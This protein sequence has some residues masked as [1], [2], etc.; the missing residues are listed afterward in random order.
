TILGTISRPRM[1]SSYS[2]GQGEA[3][4]DTFGDRN[5]SY[6][7]C[8]ANAITGN[9]HCKPEDIA[10]TTRYFAVAEYPQAGNRGKY[11][12]IAS[13]VDDTVWRWAGF[14]DVTIVNTDSPQIKY[15]VA[16]L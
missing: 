16:H 3:S 13:N 12:A 7:G 2:D 1:M 4:V 6:E 9:P 14:K 15:V 5:L 8:T 11:P 10:G